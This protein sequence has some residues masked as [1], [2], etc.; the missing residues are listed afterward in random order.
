MVNINGSKAKCVTGSLSV[1]ISCNVVLRPEG[2]AL[3][4]S[5]SLKV[6]VVFSCFMGPYQDYHV[7]VVDTLV[8]IQEYNPKNSKIYRVGDEAYLSF[9]EKTLYAL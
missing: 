5:G 9:A 8:K 7:M 3:R 4:D 2:A 1:G 6:K